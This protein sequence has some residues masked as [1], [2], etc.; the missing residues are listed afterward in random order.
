MGR[1]IHKKYFG[2]RNIGTT[3]TTD[4]GIGGQGVA[5]VT[6]GGTNSGYSAIPTSTFATGP[7]FPGGVRATGTANVGILAT[8]VAAAGTGY[9]VGDVLTVVGLGLGTAATLTVATITGVDPTG[10]IGT[11]TITTAGIY[12]SVL[13]L[14]ALAVTGGTG[15][16]ATFDVSDLT[17]VSITITNKGSGYTSAPVFTISGTATG[18]AVLTV[19]TGPNGSLTNQENAIQMIAF[20]TGGSAVLVDIVKQVSSRRYKVTDGTLTGTAALK[21]SLAS[22]AGECSIAVVDS[23]GGQYFATK[24]TAHRV[25]L[26]RAGGSG[27]LYTTGQ[28]APWKLIAPVG[29]YVQ[30][31]NA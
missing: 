4:N 13:D 23:A 22:A 29:M 30:I 7:K 5:S 31:A 2:N 18:T 20:I 28:T 17:V 16:N 19:D 12:S 10:P 24:V 6:L 21:S 26:T 11:V 27:W 3:A 8:A 14:T 15:I 1:P 9:T 25:T